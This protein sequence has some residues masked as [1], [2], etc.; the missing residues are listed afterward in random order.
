MSLACTR[1]TTRC[2]KRTLS[3]VTQGSGVTGCTASLI[4]KRRCASCRLRSV[5]FSLGPVSG[6]VP[7]CRGEPGHARPGHQGCRH[8]PPAP[9][10]WQPRWP[11]QQTLILQH[12]PPPASLLGVLHPFQGGMPL[13]W[14]L[15]TGDWGDGE[16]GSCQGWGIGERRAKGNGLSKNGYFECGRVSGDFYAV[17]VG[18]PLL[19]WA[20]PAVPLL[21][22][23]QLKVLMI[24]KPKLEANHLLLSISYIPGI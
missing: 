18:A 15:R 23:Y 12:P 13:L 4:R 7:H 24:S 21:C 1:S 9:S 17:A 14:E 6:R 11:Q 19:P 2:E 22:P 20:K 3:W 10:S 16:G 8:P 5:R